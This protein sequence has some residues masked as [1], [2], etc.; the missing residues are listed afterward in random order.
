MP[1]RVRIALALLLAAPGALA[2]TSVDSLTVEPNPAMLAGSTPQ[3]VEIAVTLNRGQF[4][5]QS[6]DVVIE[7]GDGGKPLLLT[8]ARATSERACATR[9]RSPAPMRSRR[10]PARVAAALGA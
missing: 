4:D 7:P 6:C 3:L 5:R 2:A 9:T 8:F 10:S 1:S